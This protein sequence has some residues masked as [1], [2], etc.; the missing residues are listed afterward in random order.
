MARQPRRRAVLSSVC[1]LC[2]STRVH[3]VRCRCLAISRLNNCVASLEGCA[4]SVLDNGP[5][6]LGSFAHGVT[7]EAFIAHV[8]LAW[9]QMKS[10]LESSGLQQLWYVYA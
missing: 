8:I 4:K 3:N 1:N 9:R 7:E 10:E 6:H 2:S 5:M